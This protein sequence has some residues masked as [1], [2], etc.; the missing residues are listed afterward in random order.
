MRR[1]VAAFVPA[2][3]ARA[4]TGPVAIASARNGAGPAAVRAVLVVAGVAGAGRT[5]APLAE[6]GG[7]TAPTAASEA[8]QPGVSKRCAGEAAAARRGTGFGAFSFAAA[9]PCTAPQLA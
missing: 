2:A 6:V 9:K 5:A 8:R 1:L 4:G 3:T 7:K